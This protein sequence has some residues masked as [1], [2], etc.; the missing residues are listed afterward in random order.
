VKQIDN[1]ISEKLHLNKDTKIKRDK[2][3]L[4]LYEY[5]FD[6]NNF[7]WD[8][9]ESFDDALDAIE[10]KGLYDIF[11]N[12][13]NDYDFIKS[14]IEKCKDLHDDKMH[15][16]SFNNFTNK[17]DIKSMAPSKVFKIIRKRKK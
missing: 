12:V 13:P 17:N 10:E 3:Y 6:H 16:N 1:Y 4:V 7:V 15:Y 9:F 8:A 5:D 11:I 14:F 2:V